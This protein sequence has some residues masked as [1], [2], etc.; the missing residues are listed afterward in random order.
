MVG[1]NSGVSVRYKIGKLAY[2]AY[3]F[4]RLND[5][6]SYPQGYCINIFTV[7]NKTFKKVDF[8]VINICKKATLITFPSLQDFV[9]STFVD[10]K[11]LFVI[12]SQHLKELPIN[13]CLYFSKNKILKK[14]NFWIVYPFTEDI[15]SCNLNA[16][17]KELLIELICNT[18]LRIK[19][20]NLPLSYFWASLKKKNIYIYIY[21]QLKSKAIKLVLIFC[22]A[23]LC[24]KSFSALSLIKTKEKIV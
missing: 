12:M 17:N 23:Y 1:F 9:A 3:I 19:H 15:K 5:R 21:I 7:C 6:S 16:A 22:T 20:E 11:E 13:V 24:R 14:R 4:S 2:L 10:T 8:F 18:K